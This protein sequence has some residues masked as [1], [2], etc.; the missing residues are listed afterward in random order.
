MDGLCFWTTEE[1]LYCPQKEAS[2]GKKNQD[3]RKYGLLWWTGNSPKGE[4]QR[5]H[6]KVCHF[7]LGKNNQLCSTGFNLRAAAISDL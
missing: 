5:T 4:E 7:Q 3:V 6:T 1:H 2:R